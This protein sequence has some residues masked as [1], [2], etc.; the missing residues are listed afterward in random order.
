MISFVTPLLYKYYFLGN[1]YRMFSS[2]VEKLFLIFFVFLSGWNIWLKNYYSA[3][4]I[5]CIP[6]FFYFI[7]PLIKLIY[8]KAYY[9][10]DTIEYFFGDDSFGYAIGDY[11]MEIKKQE[12]EY[13]KF[14]PNN[15]LIKIFKQKLYFVGEEKDVASVKKL[16]LQSDYKKFVTNG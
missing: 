11:K 15:L 2:L 14:Q 5:I 1:F 10:M 4:L 8:A 9:K 6:I 3:I 13:I 7:V 12:I 16:M